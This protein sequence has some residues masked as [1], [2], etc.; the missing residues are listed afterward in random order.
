VKHRALKAAGTLAGLSLLM[1]TQCQTLGGAAS[2][3]G[4]I[5]GIE[6]TGQ[7]VGAV[8]A[9]TGNIALVLGAGALT[10]IAAWLR[11]R[12]NLDK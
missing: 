1:G 5:S 3:P 2:D 4:V 10:G 11:V 9:A 12:A 6:N 8:G 7:A